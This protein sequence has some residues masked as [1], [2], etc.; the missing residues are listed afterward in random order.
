MG[1]EGNQQLLHMEIRHGSSSRV[2]RDPLPITQV[3]WVRRSLETM[4]MSARCKGWYY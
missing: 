3:A 4:M 2:Q 1:S